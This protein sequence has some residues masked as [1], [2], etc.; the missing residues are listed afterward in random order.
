MYSF[1]PS[2]HIEL[3][4]LQSSLICLIFLIYDKKKVD[5]GIQSGSLDSIEQE[6]AILR[7]KAETVESG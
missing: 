4:E 3:L 2:L 6:S 1:I 5:Q 7:L